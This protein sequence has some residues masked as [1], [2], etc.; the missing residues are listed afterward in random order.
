MACARQWEEYWSEAGDVCVSLTHD[1]TPHSHPQS[2]PSELPSKSNS[3]SLPHLSQCTSLCPGAQAKSSLM[4][5]VI[6]NATPPFTPWSQ[7]HHLAQPVQSVPNL[8]TYLHFLCSHHG[9]GHHT[10]SSR[11]GIN[12]FPVYLPT[13]ICFKHLSQIMVQMITSQVPTMAY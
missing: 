8:V 1:V 4:P 12:L 9:P 7:K 11:L 13:W 5:E 2:R 3:T 6:L 10:Q